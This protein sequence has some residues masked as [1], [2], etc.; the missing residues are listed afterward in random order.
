MCCWQAKQINEITQWPPVRWLQRLKILSRGAFVD[1]RSLRWQ[2]AVQALTATTQQRPRT[3]AFAREQ[4]NDDHLDDKNSNNNDWDDA[5]HI[6]Y[7][8]HIDSWA[9]MQKQFFQSLGFS[10]TL[11]RV[12]RWSVFLS[13]AWLSTV[14]FFSKCERFI[15]LKVTHLFQMLD[16]T[17]TTLYAVNYNGKGMIGSDWNY[18]YSARWWKT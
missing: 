7:W 17:M 12:H 6:E 18:C 5:H 1:W 2:Y 9:A 16:M 14:R 15:G 10:C 4:Y 3:S 11:Q 8:Q 13:Y